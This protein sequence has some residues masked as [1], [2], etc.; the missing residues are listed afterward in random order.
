MA[1]L[2]SIEL[3]VPK[4]IPTLAQEA[5]LDKAM[6]RRQTCPKCRRRYFRCLPLKTLGMCLLRTTRRV[7]YLATG[8]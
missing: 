2:Y 3:A 1:W 4:R 8:R 6:A 7:P 5:A